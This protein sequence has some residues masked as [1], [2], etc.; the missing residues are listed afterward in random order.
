MGNMVRH[1]L[2]LMTLVLILTVSAKDYSK[3]EKTTFDIESRPRR[4]GRIHDVGQLTAAVTN[5]GS[6]GGEANTPSMVWPAE[7]GADYLWQGSLWIGAV[8][9]GERLVSANDFNRLEF[10]PSRDFQFEFGPGKSVQ[11]H[12]AVY[13]DLEL[14][15]GHTPIGLQVHER[16][17]TWSIKGFDD[18]IIYEY[19]IENV[20]DKVLQD[21]FVGWFF[22]ADV[23]SLG[24]D[25]PENVFF[26]DD[27]VDYDGY[28]WDQ[29]KTDVVDWVDPY[30]L[31]NDG[32][33]GYDEWGWPYAFPLLK[34]GTATNPNYD[35]SAAEPDGFFDEWSLILDDNGP[36]LY[37]QTSSNP[38]NAQAGEKAVLDGK[39]LRGWLVPRNTSIM[40]DGDYPQTSVVDIG[41]RH[42]ANPTPGFI[43]GRLIYSD[44]IKNNE[45]FPYLESPDD[46]HL[47][48]YAHLWWTWENSPRSDNMRYAYLDASISTSYGL[49]K[50]YKFMPSP[51]DLNSPTFDYRWLTSTGPFKSLSP[52]E[53]IHVVFAVGIAKGWQGIRRS[54]DNALVTY[55]SG[56]QKS[57]PLNPS[58]PDEDYHY[59][60]S[61]PP[62][63]PTVEYTPL[64]GGVR[65]VWDNVAE[66]TPDPV[67]GRVDFQ[68]YKIY[69]AEYEPRNWELV[70]AF[71]NVN[72]PVFIRD[73]SGRII[74][75]KK[76]PATGQLYPYTD[77]KWEELPDETLVKVDLPPVTNHYDDFGGQFLARAIGHPVNGLPYFY[78]VVAYDFDKPQ[79]SISP[80]L[81]SQES[82]KDNYMIQRETGFPI[83][84][85]PV[86][87]Y[88]QEEL[89][90]YDLD[91]IKV[92]PNP[93]RGTAL[94]ESRYEDRIQFTNL[95]PACKITIFTLVGDMIDTIYHTDGTDAAAWDMV[96][97]NRQR[98]KSGLYIYV[99][100]VNEPE[101]GKHIGKFAIL[102]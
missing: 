98:V 9:D 34:S 59:F 63:E 25:D 48:P 67:L 37:W 35:P 32:E 2:Y 70:A 82:Q 13:D 49:G 80:E 38:A 43:G 92:V 102:R 51:F 40:Y 16:G 86:R 85:V 15:R 47:R 26:L 36:E 54:M 96:S 29:T 65:L 14:V 101:Y 87:M 76:D 94:Y 66:I 24:F 31:D 100:E 28:D 7:K 41:E 60:L 81:L 77:P 4:S 84:V 50:R 12:Y 1:V 79:T 97:R 90:S 56:S 71:D 62:P 5:Y 74:N 73:S 52:G 99:V 88:S 39:V 8:V 58:A 68:G 83:P 64:D 45:A 19:E 22:D 3:E 27:L 57:D 10:S 95:P 91:N 18:F 75:P 53:K 61:A 69:R 30:D 17:M 33:T 20:G 46:L 72:E 55:Y 42:T 78:S 44:V 21:V 23:A 93:Y 6:Y 89:G 11:D